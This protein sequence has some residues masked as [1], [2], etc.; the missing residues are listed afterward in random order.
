MVEAAAATSGGVIR[1]EVGFVERVL[2][3]LIKRSW[4]THLS[5][6]PQE[7]RR[8]CY[9]QIGRKEYPSFLERR[10]PDGTPVSLAIALQDG[11]AQR[12]AYDAFMEHFAN[13]G[14]RVVMAGVGTLE[15]GFVTK[16]DAFRW[17]AARFDQLLTRIKYEPGGFDARRHRSALVTDADGTIWP[18]LGENRWERSKAREPLTQYL[19]KGGVMVILSGSDPVTIAERLA[20]L[21]GEATRRVVIVGAGGHLMMWCGEEI[22]EYREE[23]LGLPDRKLDD[24]DMVYFDDDGRTEGNGIDAQLAAGERHFCV[25]DAEEVDERLRLWVGAHLDAGTAEIMTQ[26]LAR[27]DG[28]KPIFSGWRSNDGVA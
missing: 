24:L 26:V 10:A 7:D 13:C 8:R 25:S 16:G 23:V 20:S 12:A 27:M 1:L 21:S 4:P 18:K 28:D 6:I 9:T 17:L 15:V 3:W 5:A 22:G 19:E 11:E 2:D 14:L